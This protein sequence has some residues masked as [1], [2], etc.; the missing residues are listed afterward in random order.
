MLDLMPLE[1]AGLIVGVVLVL[2][3]T[4]SSMSVSPSPRGH[5]VL[6]LTDASGQD[7]SGCRGDCHSRGRQGEGGRSARHCS[8]GEDQ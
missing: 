8:K 4:A 6:E 3:A 7:G 5:L 1:G 2:S